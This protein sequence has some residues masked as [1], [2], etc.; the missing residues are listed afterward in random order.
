V[1][2]ISSGRYNTYRHPRPEILERYKLAGVLTMD[3]A[4]LGAIE[5]HLK[6]KYPI[7]I[8]HFSRGKLENLWYTW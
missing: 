5:L 4:K 3:T 2:I 8:H 6:A 7:G 1:A